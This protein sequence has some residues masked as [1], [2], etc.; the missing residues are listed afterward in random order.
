MIILDLWASNSHDVW[1]KYENNYD[2]LI[3]K[4]NKEIEE[5][6][7]NLDI[8]EVK[9]YSVDEFLDFLYC[10]YCKWKYTD[11]RRLGNAHTQMDKYKENADYM[12]ELF[13][14]KNALFT[15]N[16]R[17]TMLGLEICHLIRGLGYAGASGLLSILYPKYFGTVD[18]FVVISLQN[19][20]SLKN[21]EELQN[22]K[23]NDI[24]LNGAVK[25]EKLFI[26]KASELNRCNNTDYWTPRKI[27]KVLWAFNRDK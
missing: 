16:P 24:N 12:E 3:K 1:L 20:D 27:D 4:S 10:D 14:I 25:L 23:P 21:D 7:E 26:E 13:L 17:N 19:F 15:F 6:M 11:G 9:T 22:I 2:N 5:K 8:N 18:Q